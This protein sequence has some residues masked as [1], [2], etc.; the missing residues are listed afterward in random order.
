MLRHPQPSHLPGLD[1]PRAIAIVW[2][3]A[4]HLVSHGPRLPA[5]PAAGAEA[6]AESVSPR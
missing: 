2:V 6:S 1:L 3:M 4:Y 5:G